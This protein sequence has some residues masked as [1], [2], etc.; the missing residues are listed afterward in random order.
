M[1][2]SDAENFK[3][4]FTF[5]SGVK[6]SV[7]LPMPNSECINNHISNSGSNGARMSTSEM[8]NADNIC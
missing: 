3:T 6:M 1:L 7:A 5:V 2:I 4:I 8:K